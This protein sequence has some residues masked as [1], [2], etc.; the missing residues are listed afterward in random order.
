MLQVSFKLETDERLL[1]GK[2]AAAI[3]KYGVH[4]VVANVL[5]TRKDV[6]LLVGGKPH[7][8][9]AEGAEEQVQVQRVPG[10]NDGKEG[11]SI[12]STSQGV[13]HDHGSSEGGVP[14]PAVLTVRRGEGEAHI[15]GRLV[16]HIV[17][18]HKQF[19]ESNHAN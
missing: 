4:G 14:Q 7:S 2:A 18:W 13:A 3:S 6:V 17:A 10:G 9:G 15:E 19:A 12:A 16:A 1:I 5:H 11:Q 8:S